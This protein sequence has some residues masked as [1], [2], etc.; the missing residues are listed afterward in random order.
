MPFGLRNAP[1][2]IQLLMQRVLM[3][4]NP[5]EGPDFVAVYL[6]DVLVLSVTLEDHLAHLQRVIERV[7][8]RLEEEA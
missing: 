5:D 8:E 7:I 3:G 4:L 1:V 2:V 6:D